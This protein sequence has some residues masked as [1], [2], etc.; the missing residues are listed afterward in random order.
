M[1][2]KKSRDIVVKLLYQKEIVK[3]DMKELAELYFQEY[4]VDPDDMEF[5]R[6]Q[7]EGIEQNLPVID[8]QIKKHLKSWDFERLSKPDLAILRN[9]VYELLYSNDLSE[10]IIINEAVLLCK[11][12]GSD[13]SFVFVNG[14]LGNIAKNRGN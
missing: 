13:D 2:R 3:T 10:G 7:I 12:Y 5:I 1:G 11:R 9:A 8:E 14:I 6:E 4:S